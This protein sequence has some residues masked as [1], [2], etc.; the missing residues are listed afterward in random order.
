MID[1]DTDMEPLGFDVHDGRAYVVFTTREYEQG[2][3]PR[4]KIVPLHT[5]YSEGLRGP[6]PLKA[7]ETRYM[8]LMGGGFMSITADKG[9]KYK[10]RNLPIPEQFNLA[11]ARASEPEAEPEA[12][13]PLSHSSKITS[14]IKAKTETG[15]KIVSPP[16]PPIDKVGLTRAL[17]DL[18]ALEGLDE[19]KRAIRQLVSYAKRKR[20]LRELGDEREKQITLHLAITGN[21]GTGK[22]TLVDI[23]ARALKALGLLTKGHIVKCKESDLV[24]GHIGGA[25]P[26][27]EKKCTDALGGIMHIEE[28]HTMLPSEGMM[29]EYKRS[30]WNVMNDF[31]E[32]NRK[33]FAMVISGYGDRPGMPGIDTLMKRMGGV[34]SRFRKKIHTDDPKPTQLEKIFL[35]LAADAGLLLDADAEQAAFSALRQ[36]KRELG[37]LFENGRE[38]RNILDDA[39]VR[40]GERTCPADQDTPPLDTLEESSRTSEL[41]RLKTVLPEDFRSYL[42]PPLDLPA[43]ERALAELDA[44]IGQDEVK[45]AIHD[46][47]DLALDWREQVEL[48][49]ADKLDMPDFGASFHLVLTGPMGTGKTE[50]ARIYGQILRAVGWLRSGHLVEVHNAD[51][52]A[53]HVDQTAGKANEKINEALNGI[54][55]IDEAPDLTPHGDMGQADFKREALGVLSKR[56]ED[57]R[58]RLVVVMTGNRPGMEEL[59]RKEPRL[60]SRSKTFI[61]HKA[62]DDSQLVK[63]FT[64]LVKDQSFILAPGAQEAAERV[65]AQRRAGAGD[66]YGNGRDIRNMIELADEKKAARLSEEAKQLG[67]GTAPAATLTAQERAAKRNAKRVLTAEDFNALAAHTHLAPTAAPQ[68]EIGFMAVHPAKPAA[69]QSAPKAA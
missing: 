28:A 26:A 21:P 57:D 7:G 40:V 65:I 12:R 62:Y 60:I 24:P 4:Q 54:L 45:K 3:G 51:L 56:M 14:K 36:R 35:N 46:K 58:H 19:P 55:L 49:E 61:E 20:R 59:F 17:D 1:D 66:K 47:V 29:G 53:G 11:A 33:D 13:S 63:I 48:H 30:S 22:S 68:L 52:V 34:F 39:I 42:L 43:L 67:R 32:E 10:L 5:S 6:A 69:R 31:M 9:G 15:P 8:V 41:T 23:Y 27:T 25:A 38:V 50:V 2:D 18:D 37:S 16:L 64:K 44:L